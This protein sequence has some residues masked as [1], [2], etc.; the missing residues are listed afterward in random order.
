M[1]ASPPGF[2]SVLEQSAVAA[3]QE[4]LRFRNSV[5]E[6][7]A[8][9]ERERQF[10]FRRL[11]IANAMVRSA[12]RAKTV[13]EAVQN[14]TVELRRELGWHGE[15]EQRRKILD[16]WSK[17][18]TAVWLEMHPDTAGPRDSVSV[19]DAMLEFEAWY[20]GEFGSNYLALMDREIPEMPVVEF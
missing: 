12:T 19:K 3:Q 14:Q 18:A 5:A 4:E 7:I 1:I 2:L 17:V 9:R 13:E 15:T 8:K 10:A 16:R 20:T 6:E 11:E